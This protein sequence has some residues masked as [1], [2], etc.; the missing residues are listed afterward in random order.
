MLASR[1]P[2]YR[3]IATGSIG[4]VLYWMLSGRE[5]FAR[6][7]HREERWNLAGRR[8]EYAMEHVNRLLDHMIVDDPEERYPVVAVSSFLPGLIRAVDGDFWA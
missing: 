5:I 2:R 7:K 3:A 8:Q 4:K 1:M 6:E